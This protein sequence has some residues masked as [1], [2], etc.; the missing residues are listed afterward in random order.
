MAKVK[1]DAEDFR[2]DPHTEVPKSKGHLKQIIL[3]ALIIAVA[4]IVV[5]CFKN[6]GKKEGGKPNSRG[7][8]V[9]K[10]EHVDSTE[11]TQSINSSK[12]DS[13]THV[14]TSTYSVSNTLVQISG[15]LEENARQVIRGVFGNGQERKDKL[16]SAYSEIQGRVNEM[17][18]QGLV[19]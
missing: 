2:K 8:S 4:I 19:R 18:R 17:Y 10:K 12:V 11:I 6:C 9:T 13:T 14:P 3:C 7:I 1:F 15:N 16:G 5:F